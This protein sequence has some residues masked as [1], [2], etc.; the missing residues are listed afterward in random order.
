[1]GYQALS[2]NTTGSGNI[3]LGAGAGIS[4][5]TGNNNIDIG[6]GGMVGESGRIRIGDPAINTAIFIAG[7]AAMSP[8][9]PIQ[10]VLVDPVTGQL[11]SADIGSFPP[12]P[13][14][15]QGPQGPQ[16]DQGPPTMQPQSIA[17]VT[18]SGCRA[19]SICIKE[20]QRAAARSF[21]K[22]AISMIAV[23]SH[24]S[25]PRQR[26]TTKPGITPPSSPG[27]PT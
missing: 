15:A 24:H 25:H 23:W 21:P 14:G 13:Q 11:G 16:G 27:A 12:G 20:A 17:A 4:L 8:S 1:M 26:N 19:S 7:I 2:A 6:N 9:A 10:A 22:L 3:G 5:A 18:S